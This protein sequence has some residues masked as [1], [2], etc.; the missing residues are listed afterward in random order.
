MCWMTDSMQRWR[1]SR[2]SKRRN[3]NEIILKNK[4][5]TITYIAA[6]SSFIIKLKFLE[7]VNNICIFVS[8]I[9]IV[10]T[11]FFYI[12]VFSENLSWMGYLSIWV[13]PFNFLD[14]SYLKLIRCGLY[15]LCSHD[16]VID[17]HFL[18]VERVFN[19]LD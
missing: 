1:N 16:W 12:D 10:D 7:S 18:A 19:G 8:D 5:N 9:W 17:L 13:F 6:R 2:N 14:L 3:P 11:W 15:N 4:N